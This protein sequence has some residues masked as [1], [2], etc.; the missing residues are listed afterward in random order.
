MGGGR[1]ELIMG[2][3]FGGKTSELIRKIGRYKACQ[4]PTQLF[5]PD[6]RY[7]AQHVTS[8]D[9][10]KTDAEYVTSLG[11]LE[12]MI[13]PETKVIGIDEAQFYPDGIIN[14]CKNQANGGRIVVVAALSKD[15]KGRAF[16]F[17]DSKR[18]VYD[19]A[20]EADHVKVLPSLCTYSDNGNLPCAS[21]ASWVQRFINGEV[22]PGDSPLVMEGAQEAYA[23]RCREHFVRYD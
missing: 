15:F 20:I 14:L 6:K 11:Q 22:A 2:N 4:R 8:H 7:S 10:A 18:T 16:A 12:E 5:K 23:P 9:A 1:I 19:L 13:L 21:D 3:M 17:K